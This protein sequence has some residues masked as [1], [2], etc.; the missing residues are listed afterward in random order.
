MQPIID[1]VTQ[2]LDLFLAGNAESIKQEVLSRHL[3]ANSSSVIMPFADA[4]NQRNEPIEKE[5]QKLEEEIFSICGRR[6]QATLLLLFRRIPLLLGQQLSRTLLPSSSQSFA[7]SGVIHDSILFGTNAI[8]LHSPVSFLENFSA[9]Y[10][11]DASEADFRDSYELS[12]LCFLHRMLMYQLNT[13]A[14][15]NLVVSVSFESLIDVYNTRLKAHN[16]PLRVDGLPAI[17]LSSFLTEVRKRDFSFCRRGGSEYAIFLRNFMPVLIDARAEHERYS[18]L[19]SGIFFQKT[20]LAFESAW[21]IWIALNQVLA[22]SLIFFWPQARIDA[23]DEAEALAAAERADDFTETCLGGGR[24]SSLV[25]ATKIILERS[26]ELDASRDCH[27]FIDYLTFREIVQDVRFIEQPFL[28]YPL[29]EDLLLWDYLRHGGFMKAIARGLS[30]GG[31]TGNLAGTYFEASV[32][33]CIRKLPAV[34]GLRRNVKIRRGKSVAWEI[35]LGFA[36]SGILILVEAKHELKPL[37]YHFADSVDVADRVSEFE[38]RLAELDELLRT[39]KRDVFSRWASSEPIG[40]ICVICTAEVE[41]IAS[42]SPGLWLDTG[43]IPRILTP[44]EL[45]ECLRE[46]TVDF[47]S[48]PEFVSFR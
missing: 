11:I 1:L 2:R 46:E 20:G 19:A 7:I 16:K 24:R 15:R 21:K 38:H 10:S 27:K 31:A 28:F 37:R 29:G 14:R 41:F 13:L 17:V 8:L 45:A 26:K 5:L 43:R 3:H 34:E 40:A 47:R 36:V 23:L 18:H 9:R 4:L 39:H 32:E 33:G 48:H 30:R 6:D 35:D 12:I 42:F 25:H 22:E 44:R